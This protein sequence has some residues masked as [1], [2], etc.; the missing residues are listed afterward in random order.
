[1]RVSVC[2]KLYVSAVSPVSIDGFL[3]NFCH[4]CILDN[5]ELIRFWGQKVKGQGDINTMRHPALD[6]AIMKLSS[7]YLLF[8]RPLLSQTL[9]AEFT[10]QEN[11][12][13][14]LEADVATFREEQKF[15]AADRL[16]QQLS[17]L[18]VTIIY[19]ILLSTLF[20]YL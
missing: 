17:L 10:Q 19:I 8:I 13:K 11:M 4:W 14:D 7:I 9:A 6:P 1:M 20:T 3:L 2:P 5:N 12:L 16:E 15:E 18:R